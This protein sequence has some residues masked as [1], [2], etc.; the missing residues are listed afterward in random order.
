[1]ICVLTSDALEYDLVY[2]FR[3]WGWSEYKVNLDLATSPRQV[4]FILTSAWEMTAWAFQQNWGCIRGGVTWNDA[5]EWAHEHHIKVL[6]DD[7][8][9]A[10]TV[11]SRYPPFRH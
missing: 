9:L 4:L 3:V 5:S 1:V 8:W 7:C 2:E 10:C 11:D 6:L